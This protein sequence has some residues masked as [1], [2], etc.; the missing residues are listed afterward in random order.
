MKKKW[1]NAIREKQK[2]GTVSVEKKVKEKNPFISYQPYIVV[3]H[4]IYGLAIFSGIFFLVYNEWQRH[5]HRH[6]RL[7]IIAKWTSK[8]K[9]F[10]FRFLWF[11]SMVVNFR[12]VFFCAW[13]KNDDEKEYLKNF[14]QSNEI[15][16][17]EK[18]ASNNDYSNSSKNTW[19]S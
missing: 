14:I 1:V 16:N 10:I 15:N 6:T 4:K 12:A 9:L 17:K 11:Y 2:C 8:K 5:T 18:Q 13:E 7:F 3:R 19:S